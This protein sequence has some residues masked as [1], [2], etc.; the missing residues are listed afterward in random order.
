MRP[1]L[2][3]KNG[4][5]SE[6]VPIVLAREP[7]K[8]EEDVPFAPSVPLPVAISH[9]VLPDEPVAAASPGPAV[10]LDS[11]ATLDGAVA[12]LRRRRDV[13]PAL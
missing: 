8:G 2:L 12:A 3:K 10:A 1:W 7:V 4:L 9:P 5:M 13:L 6:E 11:L